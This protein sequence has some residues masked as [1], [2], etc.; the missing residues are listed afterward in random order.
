ME[1]LSAMHEASETVR[2]AM[3]GGGAYS[4]VGGFGSYI[5]HLYNTVSVWTGQAFAKPTDA[6][7][8][9]SIFTDYIRTTDFDL[10][11]DDKIYAIQVWH[12]K[13]ISEQHSDTDV[14]F[15]GWYGIYI[16]VPQKPCTT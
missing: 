6:D 2:A 4:K 10:E 1:F 8:T 13:L 16:E 3:V 9:I 11:Y 7:R 14:L 5:G 12:Y 15:L